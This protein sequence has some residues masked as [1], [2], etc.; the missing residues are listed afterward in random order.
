M[1]DKQCAAGVLT[2]SRSVQHQIANRDARRRLTGKKKAAQACALRVESLDS[3]LLTRDV[4]DDDASVARD[5]ESCGLND[6]TL[7]ASDLDNL[8]R[9]G[10]PSVD[11]VDGMPAPV[12]DVV[13]A[14]RRLLK[15]DRAFEAANDVWRQATN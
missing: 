12:E 7:F 6:A 8:L 11:G 9:A 5:V 1:T 10:A 14:A 4:G 2:R 13:D 3:L 15:T